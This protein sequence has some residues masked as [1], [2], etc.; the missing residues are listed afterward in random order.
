M[1]GTAYWNIRHSQSHGRAGWDL[2]VPLP[3]S[4]LKLLKTGAPV[5]FIFVFPMRCSALRTYTLY[6]WHGVARG[7][8]GWHGVAWDG[9]GWG[10][11]GWGGVGGN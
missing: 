6:R 7:G 9:V 11:M 8:M 5:L 1:V 3:P 10:G 2:R 4:P